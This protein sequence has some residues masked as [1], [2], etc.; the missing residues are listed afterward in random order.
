MISKFEFNK[1]KRRRSELASLVVLN[2]ASM[3]HLKKEQ[4]EVDEAIEQKRKLVK[5]TEDE[6]ASNHQQSTLLTW[7]KKKDKDQ[8]IPPPKPEE[9]SNPSKRGATT[10]PAKEEQKENSNNQNE[11]ANGDLKKQRITWGERVK[12]EA[13][14]LLK[15]SS[16]VNVYDTF[17]QRIPLSNIYRWRKA[18][19][20]KRKVGSG[21]KPIS[22][23][24]D[25]VLF[26]W[27]LVGR[28]RKIDIDDDILQ[29]KALKFN[30]AP[31]QP[32]QDFKASN[33][34]LWGFKGGFNIVKRCIPTPPKKKAPMME[35]LFESYPNQIDAKIP[36]KTGIWGF[37]GVPIFFG[38]YK[39]ATLDLGPSGAVAV[40]PSGKGGC[41]ITATLGAPSL[42]GG[43]PLALILKNDAQGG[44]P[45]RVSKKLADL[46]KEKNLIL[47]QNKKGWGTPK[48]MIKY[49]IPKIP[50]I[51]KI[52]SEEHLI[53]ADNCTSH[54]HIDVSAAY[55]EE[56]LNISFLPQNLQAYSNLSMFRLENHSSQK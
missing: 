48:L 21:R 8:D 34:W 24:L 44:I 11:D 27:F 14:E 3:A 45:K 13:I 38:V 28:A 9:G 50:P 10:A 31:P 5:K 56:N 47:L 35:P 29:R 41:R 32:A 42:G 7:Y 23:E 2:E 16:V 37:D 33:G 20:G 15:T 52:E 43:P 49:I 53:L 54:A 22:Q 19:S 12:T 6:S 55:Q 25:N 51:V 4:K 18:L 17:N 1:L 46:V 40:I 26:E 36:P 30:R 39:G